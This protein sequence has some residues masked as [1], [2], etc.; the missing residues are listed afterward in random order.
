[1]GG[2]DGAG[3]V[4]I[5]V[6]LEFQAVLLSLREDNLKGDKNYMNVTDLV[7]MKET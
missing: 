6:F 7:Q 2:D 5:K 1:M 4:G 3:R